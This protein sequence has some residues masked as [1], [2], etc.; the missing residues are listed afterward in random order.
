MTS[1]T[2][3]YNDLEDWRGAGSG[4]A[5]DQSQVPAALMTVRDQNFRARV[6]EVPGQM[7]GL[8]DSRSLD[9]HALIPGTAPAKP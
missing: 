4:S 3:E 8:I 1:K 2:S 6:L 9:A 7:S 5:K